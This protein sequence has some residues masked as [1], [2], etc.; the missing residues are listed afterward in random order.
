MGKSKILIAD[1]EFY[2]RDIVK[3]ALDEDFIVIEAS[4]GEEA[5]AIARKQKPDLI[6]IDILLPKLDGVSACYLLKSNNRTSSIP[7]VIISGRTDRLKQD[8]IEEIGADGYLSK[9]FDVQELFDKIN[10][11]IASNRRCIRLNSI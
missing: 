4:D 2:I 9:P 3:D 10:R 5:I 7:V 8:C 11:V 6:I 1:D